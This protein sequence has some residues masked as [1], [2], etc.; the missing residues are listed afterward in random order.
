[1][2]TIYQVRT[3]V[4]LTNQGWEALRFPDRE[5]L[6]LGSNT[7]MANKEHEV[8]VVDAKGDAYRVD[9]TLGTAK[10]NPPI[11]TSQGE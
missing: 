2:S 6:I 7:Y 9:M 1:M 8:I 5:H 4:E 10:S 11:Y 3:V